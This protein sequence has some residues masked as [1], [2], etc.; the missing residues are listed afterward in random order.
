MTISSSEGA[1]S[2]RGWEVSDGH[3]FA[4]RAFASCFI[5]GQG[6]VLNRSQEL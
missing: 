4:A 5:T 2:C 1:G 6:W 3:N